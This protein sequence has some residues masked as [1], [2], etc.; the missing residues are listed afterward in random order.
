MKKQIAVVAI[1]AVVLCGCSDENNSSEIS[2]PESISSSDSSE[3]LIS[4]SSSFS[5]EDS[6]ISPESSQS[7]SLG[8][9]LDEEDIYYALTADE[10]NFVEKSLFVG[11]SICKGWMTY[12]VFPTESVFATGSVGTR[13]IFDA[14]F[15]CYGKNMKFVDVFEEKNPTN[16]FF[17]MGINDVNM[18]SSKK[19]CENY[20]K[21]IDF[22]L[23]NTQSEVFVCAITPICS[24]FTP[25]GRIE[26][27]NSAA[28]K[29]IEEKYSER[30]HF[31]DYTEPLKDK[32]GK[33]KSYF[34]GGDGIH[35]APAAYYA[36]IHELYALLSS[37]DYFD[38]DF[39]VPARPEQSEPEQSEPEQSEPEQ[40]EPEQ[41]EPEQ[42][43]LEQTESEQSESEQSDPTESAEQEL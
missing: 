32:D 24:D 19:F 31:I 41:S 8:G 3:N 2:V 1:L 36:S 7:E 37:S 14:D 35:L 13:N 4:S 23:N 6:E 39:T 17:S 43:E 33:L 42:S 10:K 15:L 21:L 25:D 16:V 12:N 18:I 38:P 26:E 22:V 9:G 30:V 28:K 29:Y 5:T 20:S 40:S 11:D 34:S 27:F